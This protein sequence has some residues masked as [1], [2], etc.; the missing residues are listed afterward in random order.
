MIIVSLNQIFGRLISITENSDD[1]TLSWSATIDDLSNVNAPSPSTNDVITWDG[2]EW[3]ADVVTPVVQGTKTTDPTNPGSDPFDAH[4]DWVNADGLLAGSIGFDPLD[5]EGQIYTISNHVY[6]AQLQISSTDIAG[7][8]DL[9]ISIDAD[10]ANS[11]K[12]YN[13]GKES[14]H[15]SSNGVSVLGSLNNSPTTGGVQDARYNLKNSGG[16]LTGEIGFDSWVDLTISNKVHGGKFRVLGENTAGAEK[17]LIF[18]NPNTHTQ[19]LNGS[20]SPE[21]AVLGQVGS[22]Y[23]R[24]DGGAGTSFYVKESGTGTTGWVAK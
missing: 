5:T 4:L 18:L 3:V 21:G 1:I 12:F 11:P 17:Q 16:T 9:A 22:I 19:I 14:A 24:S 6:G 13:L 7:N 10:D 20:G 23:M 2:A 8:L 15:V